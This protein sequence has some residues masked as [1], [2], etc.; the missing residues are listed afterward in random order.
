MSA[1]PFTQV[2]DK[3]WELLEA[4]SEVTDLVAARNR[5]KLHQSYGR[6][7]KLKQSLADLPE[8]IIEP[9]GGGANVHGTST[10]AKVIQ[11]YSI[12]LKGRDLRV[13]AT[14]FP[15]KWAV[16]KALASTDANLGLSFVRN[17]IIEDSRD[18][19]R[20]EQ[21]PG[22]ESVLEVVVEMW[23]SRDSMKG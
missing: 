11:R 12:G 15:L 14:F 22:W 16:L 5:I 18:T 4:Q 3:L 7:E 13:H 9:S 6:P 20:E 1:D 23:F 10:H 17:V 21:H 19:P 8:L 2:L